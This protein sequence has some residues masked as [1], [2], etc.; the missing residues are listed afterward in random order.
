MH[1][2]HGADLYQLMVCGLRARRDMALV[3]TMVLSRSISN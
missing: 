2:I 3:W 1:G